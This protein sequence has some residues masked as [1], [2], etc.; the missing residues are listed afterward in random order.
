MELTIA[1]IPIAVLRDSFVNSLYASVSFP[2]KSKSN[3]EPSSCNPVRAIA[4]MLSIA[5]ALPSTAPKI[6][7]ATAAPF[8]ALANNLA[9]TVDAPSCAVTS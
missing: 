9:A 1:S 3:K 6:P 5:K 8:K 7:A 2:T 4:I